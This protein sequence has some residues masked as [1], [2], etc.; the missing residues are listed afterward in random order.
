MWAALVT[1]VAKL[2]FVVA[3]GRL[4]DEAAQELATHLECLT[5]RYIHSGMTPAEARLA[6]TRQL[7]NVTLVREDIYRMNSIRWLDT[8]TQDSRYAFRVFARNRAFAGVVVV[9]LALG[10]GANIAIF[11]VVYSLLLKPL[12]YAAPDELYSVEVVIPERRDQIPSLPVTV[13]T[14]R[15]WRAAPT[16]FSVMGALRP[17]EANLSGDG[18]PE[19]LGGA[20]V[21]ANFF[22]V[23]GVAMARGRAFA[24]EEEQPGKELVVVISDRLW[25][26]RYA[27][28][29]STIGRT[30]LINGESHTVVGIAP[31][32]LLVPTGARLHA[33][34]PFASRIDIWKPIAP[35]ITQLNNESWDHGVLVRLPD[36]ANLEQGRQQLAD[37][38]NERARRQMPGVKT[39]A[40]IQFVPF[41]EI[42]SG[43][44]RLRLLLILAASSLLLLTACASIANVF[45]ARVA[46]RAHEFA[47]RVAIGAGR[48]RILSQTLTEALLLSIIGGAIAALIARYG[49]DLLAA[50]G[51]DDLRQISLTQLNL[52]LV[53]FGMVVTLL[54]GVVCGIVPAWQAYRGDT[55]TELREAARSAMGGRRAA[56]SRRVLIGVETALATMLLACAG[57]LLHSFVKLMSA[58]RGYEVQRVLA[59]DLSLFGQRYSAA[60]GRS[61]FYGELLERVRALPGVV[62][63]GAISNLPA[64]SAAGDGASRPILYDT[65][66]NFQSVV[67]ARPVAAI[68]S[69]TAGYFQGSGSVLRAGRLLT[70]AEQTPVAV[71]SDALA[72]RL[73]PG[74][75][76]TAVVGRSFRQGGN[77]RDPLVAVVGVASDA[78]PGGL[79]RDPAPVVYR[80]YAQWSSGPMTL[81]VRTA[82]EPG[83]LAGAVRSEIRAMDPN[84]PI[85]GMRTMQEIVSSTVAERRFQM[86]VTSVFALVALLLG[87]VGVYGVVSYSVSSRIR[88]I[89]LRMALGA[90]RIDVMRWVFSTGMQPVLLGIAAGLAGA[91]TAAIGMRSLLY[92]IA[93]ADPL[94]LGTV[95]LVLLLTSSLACYLPARRAATLD[96][97][98]ALRCE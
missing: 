5:S 3:R 32:S 36:A 9:T 10:I 94:A 82:Q 52:P 69:V 57:L 39:T 45:M 78:Q 29:P 37:I 65:D 58:D 59:V 72:R 25:R 98:T 75:S 14:Y 97:I 22:D 83:G 93:P 21:S 49:A 34:I 6:A 56:R 73:W 81:V 20:R 84:L 48:G 44:I 42:Y 74:E 26:A 43:Q 46:S 89:G 24:A 70:D 67:L 88:D 85:A 60:A 50:F 23:L 40:A 79:D 13:Q 62:A 87:S 47:T 15:D 7:G 27:A 8:L 53:V 68:R 80:P 61:A 4:Q 28:D 51:P 12:P 90:A 96:P 35:T 18:E 31:A 77:F 54:T 91:V 17:W 63:A 33:L 86:M 71:I 95:A 66:T 92:G 1:L 76:S 2:R 41:R 38:L 64:L 30:M 19:R 16:A 55:G 11:S